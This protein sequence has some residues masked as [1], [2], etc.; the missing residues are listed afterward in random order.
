MFDR[1]IAVVFMLIYAA[2]LGGLAATRMWNALFVVAV[3][4]GPLCS[5]VWWLTLRHTQT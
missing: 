2:A 3:I 4:G 1:R 5:L